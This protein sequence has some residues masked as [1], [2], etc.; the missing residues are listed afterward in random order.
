MKFKI[1]LILLLFIVVIHFNVTEHVYGLDNN[2]QL[3]L[4]DDWVSL[5]HIV[6]DPEIIKQLLPYDCSCKA[7]QLAYYGITG[8]LV[9][10]GTIIDL[11]KPR[12]GYGADAKMIQRGLDCLNKEYGTNVHLSWFWTDEIGGLAGAAEL[13]RTGQYAIFQ[14][15]PGHFQAIRGINIKDKLLTIYNS[16]NN[17]TSTSGMYDTEPGVYEWSFERDYNL[18]NQQNWAAWAVL[19][20]GAFPPAKITTLNKTGGTGETVELIAN[21]TDRD[22]NGVDNKSVIFNVGDCQLNGTTINGLVKV[23]YPIKQS[24]GTYDIIVSYL[25]NQSIT[26]KGILN[27]SAVTTNE[28]DNYDTV[29]NSMGGMLMPTSEQVVNTG[30]SNTSIPFLSLFILSTTLIFTLRW[31]K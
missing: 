24:P 17:T 28:V 8:I 19:K 9:D 16:L 1:S 5:P 3:S 30:L 23:L 4:D 15:L 25:D 29:E 21:L 31:K 10:E 12:P 7:I 26:C 13:Y 2:V 20:I 6:D 27:V 22:D 18:I 11:V 14:N